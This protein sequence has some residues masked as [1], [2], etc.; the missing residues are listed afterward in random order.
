MKMKIMSSTFVRWALGGSVA[1]LGACGS[2]AADNTPIEPSRETRISN[3][4]DKACDRYDSC[5][6]YGSDKTYPS[7]AECEADFT[8]KAGTMW[9]NDTC[10]NGRIN[11]GRYDTCVSAAEAVA[12][13]GTVLDVIAALDDCNASKV[14][15]DEPQ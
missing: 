14:C 9:P 12:C 8:N 13:G 2:D 7:E 10:G 15:T 5:T 3:L 4:A 6:G 11:N 1:F